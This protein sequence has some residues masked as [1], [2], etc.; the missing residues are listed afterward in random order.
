MQFAI[1]TRDVFADCLQLLQ[2][3]GA[4]SADWFHQWSADWRQRSRP[5]DAGGW[6]YY[7][8]H[9]HWRRENAQKRRRET[10]PVVD[11]DTN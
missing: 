10:S 1:S 2:I 4:R 6:S 5:E 9:C 3:P 11:A 7:S 8:L